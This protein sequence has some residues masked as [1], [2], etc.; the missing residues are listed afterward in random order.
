[1]KTR[2]N[3][4]S[5]LG[6]GLATAAPTAALACSTDLRGD[7]RVRCP[8]VGPIQ[9]DAPADDYPTLAF[10]LQSKED[11]VRLAPGKDG[12]LW[13]KVRDVWKRVALE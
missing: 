9:S 7:R 8:T 4:L 12:R 11:A 1:M 6:I 5:L 2:R 10:T 3:F 13:M